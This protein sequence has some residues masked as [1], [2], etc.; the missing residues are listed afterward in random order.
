MVKYWN[1]K[2][3][4]ESRLLPIINITGLSVDR[5]A[6]D[7]MVKPERLLKV[8][9][10]YA[11]FTYDEFI[12]MI[13]YMSQIPAIKDLVNECKLAIKERR[14]EVIPEKY[15]TCKICNSHYYK[16]GHIPSKDLRNTICELEL[17][18]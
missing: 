8:I 10:G 3:E 14:K 13:W 12:M 17:V 16:Q 5:I 9:K 1:V 11:T 6:N 2:A 7:N 15:A 18:L 4:F